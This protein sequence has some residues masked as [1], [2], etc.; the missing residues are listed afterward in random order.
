M[1][2]REPGGPNYTNGSGKML[3]SVVPDP[4]GTQQLR[5]LR[6][7]V[8]AIVSQLPGRNKERVGPDGTSVYMIPSSGRA[9][10]RAGNDAGGRVRPGTVRRERPEPLLDPDAFR[11]L[12][13]L[14]G[15]AGGG[16]A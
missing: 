9:G 5:V 7:P 2:I 16:P 8:I 11:R 1:E 15:L 14:Q 3:L 4:V 10:H 6:P 13:D 12:S